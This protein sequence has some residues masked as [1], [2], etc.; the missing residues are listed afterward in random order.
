[1]HNRETNTR[2]SELLR[3]AKKGLAMHARELTHMD[4][5]IKQAMLCREAI[6]L[7]SA[8]H[9]PLPGDVIAAFSNLLISE[10]YE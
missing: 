6:Y 7:I 2:A 4:S 3:K 9:E 10:G 5:T 1:M 8:Q